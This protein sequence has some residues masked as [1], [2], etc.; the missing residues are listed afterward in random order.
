MPNRIATPVPPILA[1]P[2]VTGLEKVF[3][4]PIRSNTTTITG[5]IARMA[6]TAVIAPSD[7]RKYGVGDLN[8]QP[9]RHKVGEARPE[10][11]PPFLS[12]SSTR[13]LG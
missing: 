4:M 12:C 6:I 11:I 9:A 5:T 2:K 13:K 3:Q 1:Y 8:E 10:Y 7:M